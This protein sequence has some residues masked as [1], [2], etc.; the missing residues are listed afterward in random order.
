ML[1]SRVIYGETLLRRCPF[2]PILTRMVYLRSF[3]FNTLFYVMTACMVLVLVP[4]LI[5]P[6]IFVRGVGYL[7]GWMTTQ[8]LYTAGIR[9]HQTGAVHL[10][11]QVIYAAKHQSAW[12]T[13][14]LLWML[15]T[16][17]MVLKRS[18][19]F[20]PVIGFFFLRGGCIPVDRKAGM[21]ALKDMRTAAAKF[22][23]RG[24]S[25]MIFPQGTR[26]APGVAH[27]YEIG[28]F[29]IYDA[30]GLPVV[31]IALNSGHVWPRNSWRKYPGRIDVEFLQPI[32]PGLSRK[33]FMATLEERIESRMRVLDRDHYPEPQQ[34]GN[35]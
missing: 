26:V 11:R 33:E 15:R 13:I 31:P 20:L 7:W 2:H 22:R 19:L 9:H 10:D 25:I 21:R 34:E 17:V 3:I 24:R 8:L 6:R 5:L 14:V 27:S 12:E 16:P 35:L 32:E 23:E 1:K 29:A 4:F 18:L 30:T 28:V